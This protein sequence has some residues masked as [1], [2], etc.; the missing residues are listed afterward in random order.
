MLVR[1]LWLVRGWGYAPEECVS[2]AVRQGLRAGRPDRIGEHAGIRTGTRLP[3][4]SSQSRDLRDR[5]M[6]GPMAC[7]PLI[8]NIPSCLA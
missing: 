3:H 2:A 8:C 1:A 6:L 4:R 7:P 5:H